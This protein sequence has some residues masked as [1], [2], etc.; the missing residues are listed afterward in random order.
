MMIRTIAVLGFCTF[1]ISAA[2]GQN[3]E[4]PW[5]VVDLGGGAMSST[6][7]LA[8]V[9]AGQTA[10]GQMSSTSYQSFIGFWQIE[11]TQVGI[12]E[13]SHWT[14]TEPLA[15]RLYAPYPNPCPSN[16]APAIHYSLATESHVS[17]QLYDLLGRNVG[18]LVNARQKPGKY[19]VGV[20]SLGFGISRLGPGLCFLRMRTGDYQATRKLVLQ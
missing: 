1:C 15:T 12:Q 7:Y 2:L 4:C 20:W 5:S 8:G 13:E 17:I 16:T 19:S 6:S 10:V 14:I 18:T 9:S 11:T 3:Y